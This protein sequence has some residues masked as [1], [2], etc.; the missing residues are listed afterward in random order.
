[1]ANDDY[2]LPVTRPQGGSLDDDT[3]PDGLGN[4][5]SGSDAAVNA[6]RLFP[7]TEAAQVMEPDDDLYAFDSITERRAMRLRQAELGRRMQLIAAAAL[8]EWEKKL[9][10]GAPLNMSREDAEKLRDAGAKLEREAM[11]DDASMKPN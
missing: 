2:K 9:S 5:G 10:R 1:M 11:D 8:E 3:R 6:V 7:A 4:S